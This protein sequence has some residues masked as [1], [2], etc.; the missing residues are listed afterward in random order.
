MIVMET[1]VSIITFYLSLFIEFVCCLQQ[2]PAENRCAVKQ[3]YR[4]NSPSVHVSCIFLNKAYIVRNISKLT[5]QEFYI[6]KR[7]NNNCNN[8]LLLSFYANY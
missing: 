4:Q 1:N 5:I 3:E 2:S 8:I 7:S 6:V